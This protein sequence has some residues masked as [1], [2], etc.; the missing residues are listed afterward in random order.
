MGTEASKAVFTSQDEEIIGVDEDSE[1][2]VT[3]EEWKAIIQKKI[4]K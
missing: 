4:K 1:A 2:K 3:A